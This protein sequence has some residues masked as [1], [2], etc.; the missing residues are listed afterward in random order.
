MYQS[1]SIACR[2]LTALLAVL[3]AVGCFTVGV[4]AEETTTELK[5]KTFTGQ[6]LYEATESVGTIN[7]EGMPIYTSYQDA[8]GRRSLMPGNFM[9][10]SVPVRHMDSAGNLKYKDGDELRIVIRVSADDTFTD[11]ELLSYEFAYDAT[12]GRDDLIG[13]SVIDYETYE[14]AET[15][16]DETTGVSYKEFELVYLLN[17]V[18]FDDATKEGQLRGMAMSQSSVTVYFLGVYN[19]TS[20]ETVVEYDGVQIS[21]QGGID[22]YFENVYPEDDTVSG[23]ASYASDH[24]K[25]T[26]RDWNFA[27]YCFNAFGANEENPFLLLSGLGA[28]LPAGDYALDIEMSSMIALIT[29]N[30]CNVVVYDGDTELGSLVVSE[31]MVNSAAGKDTGA[32]AWYRLNFTVP[33]ESAGHNITFKIFLF[34]SND[35]KFRT[36]RLSQCNVTGT[37]PDD[38]KAVLDQINALT[39]GN[40]EAIAA[41]RAAFD[42]LDIIGQAW[43]GEDAVRRLT[44]LEESGAVIDVIAALGDASAVTK[45]NYTDYTEALTNAEAQYKAFLNQYGEENTAELITNAQALT[46]FRTAYDAAVAAAEEAKK[47]AAIDNVKSLIDA[48]GEVTEDNYADKLEPI[49]AAED[50]LDELRSTYGSEIDSEVSNL[51]TLT[52]AR[53]KYDEYAAKPA[54]TYGDVN[55]D[56]SINASDALEVLQHSVQ[57]KTLEGDALTA[58]D[59]TGEGEVNATDALNILQYSVKLIDHFPVEEQ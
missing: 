26:G 33:E 25:A 41:A 40:T 28:E 44:S 27:P 35:I 1:K 37:I 36:V 30:K 18:D 4:S 42:A 5:L 21:A 43:V 46:D 7:D 50:A 14:S 29:L 55:N 19:E 45:D 51:T 3:M 47:Q 52:D 24:D 32:Y 58:A 15:K 48:I 12:L 53:A 6:E 39:A 10:H 22:G 2:F 38:A 31:E 8:I 17:H 11:G 16:V 9:F 49:E 13:N 20:G 23:V 56:G 59:V 54:V 34:D 57:L